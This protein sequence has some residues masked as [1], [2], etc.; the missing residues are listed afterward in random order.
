MGWELTFD[1]HTHHVIPG[2]PW[3]QNV[4]PAETTALGLSL[5]GRPDPAETLQMDFVS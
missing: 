3:L 2:G 5:L 4:A 1:V